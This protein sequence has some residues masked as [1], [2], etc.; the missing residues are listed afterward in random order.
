VNTGRP[1]YPW[2][3]IICGLDFDP[4]FDTRGFFPRLFSDC[5]QKLDFIFLTQAF[6]LISN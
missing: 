4:K 6:F 5:F 1:R 2:V 3:L